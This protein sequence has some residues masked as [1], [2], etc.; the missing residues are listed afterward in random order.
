MDIILSLTTPS[1]SLLRL[2][3][4]LLLHTELALLLGLPHNVTSF[5]PTAVRR[6]L[7][8]EQLLQMSS[9]TQH[10]QTHAAAQLQHKRTKVG[11][12]TN[13]PSSLHIGGLE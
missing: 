11:L 2:Y 5:Y 13:I 6:A 4:A 10:D 9:D 1:M 8:K 7:K 3:L 12:G